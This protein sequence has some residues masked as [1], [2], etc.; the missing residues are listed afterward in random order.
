M[1]TP[2]PPK[3]LI[4]QLSRLKKTEE[5]DRVEPFSIFS[6]R[7]RQLKESQAHETEKR[8]P[9]N[10]S[11]SHGVHAAVETPDDQ[12]L[13]GINISPPPPKPSPSPEIARVPSRKATAPPVPVP[14]VVQETEPPPSSTPES[15]PAP[16][17]APEDPVHPPP[18]FTIATPVPRPKPTG[19]VGRFLRGARLNASRRLR[20]FHSRFSPAQIL[21]LYL[22]L[23][24]AFS[25]AVSWKFLQQAHPAG[26][27]GAESEGAPSVER[28]TARLVK[29]FGR[30]DLDE[31]E[32]IASSLTNSFPTDPRSYTAVGTVH[33]YRKEY[34]QARAAYTKA[35]DLAPDR[36]EVLFSLAETEFSSR[37]FA[38]A[39]RAYER[40]R[41]S[42]TGGA[43]STLRLFVC[44]NAIGDQQAADELL[45][46]YPF[47]YQSLEWYW[48]EALKA[49]HEGRRE[50]AERI[51]ATTHTIFGT[52]AKSQ[53]R[54]FEELGWP[55]KDLLAP[56]SSGASR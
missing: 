38:N 3:R 22:A 29:A 46:R 7:R 4:D 37:N 14:V 31:A 43:L 6:L 30:N 9:A 21:C 23:P 40:L 10:K 17:A 12:G 50:E 8:N 20:R 15:L 47:P 56:A 52:P 41:A 53:A 42:R 45:I 28:L 34:D 24:L 48:V 51:I 36:P 27:P 39:A 5:D 32:S 16:E 11:S 13:A 25:V 18:A 54:S 1:E 19:R 2:K 55:E 26:A 49:R 44:Y 33:A 35:L